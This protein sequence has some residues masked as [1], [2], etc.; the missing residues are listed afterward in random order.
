MKY[1]RYKLSEWFLYLGVIVIPDKEI[2]TIISAGID[3]AASMI[4]NELEEHEREE[5]SF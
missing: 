3:F 5:E 1:L 4:L 2:R